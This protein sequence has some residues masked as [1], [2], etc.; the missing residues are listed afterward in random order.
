MNG[1]DYHETCSPVIKPATI[2]MVLA[3]AVTYNWPIRQLDVSNAFL[4][5]IVH[6]KSTWSNL[7]SPCISGS[8]LSK[9][10]GEPLLNPSEY[11]HVVGA[12]QYV[13]LT[14]PD[15]Q[16]PMVDNH[17]SILL[18]ST[19]QSPTTLHWTAAK[20]VQRYSECLMWLW[21]GWKSWWQ[22]ILEFFLAIAWSYGQLRNNMLS[23]ALVLKSCIDL[24]HWLL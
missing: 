11:R 13:T 3:V 4:C 21:L 14:R 8:K 18:L 19:M 20:Q 15:M 17:C 16:S 1:I 9:F 23:L 7:K 10:E 22:K 5:G 24:W 12:I 6:E 2:R